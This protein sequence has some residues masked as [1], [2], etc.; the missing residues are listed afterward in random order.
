[1]ILQHFAISN[2]FKQS[3]V[4]LIRKLFLH[5]L[6]LNFSQIL[7]LFLLKVLFTKLC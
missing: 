6:D 4:L 7:P 2:I 1:L 3:I 5:Y